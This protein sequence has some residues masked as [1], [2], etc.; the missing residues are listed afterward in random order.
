MLF[1]KEPVSHLSDADVDVKSSG[2]LRAEVEK[3]SIG[4]LEKSS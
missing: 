1:G 2:E 3:V 4:D